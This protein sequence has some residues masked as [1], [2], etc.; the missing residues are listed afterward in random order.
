M[1][2]NVS[3]W[4][5]FGD[6][7]E[8]DDKCRVLQDG[9]WDVSDLPFCDIE[10]AGGSDDISQHKQAIDFIEEHG[11]E[12]VFVANAYETDRLFLF[13]GKPSKIDHNLVSGES[14]NYGACLRVNTENIKAI[15]IAA[16]ND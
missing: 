5:A 12:N 16:E 3:F 13:A 8:E 7:E 9:F 10:E 1:D 6:G 14:P 11:I 15:F 2:Y 4:D